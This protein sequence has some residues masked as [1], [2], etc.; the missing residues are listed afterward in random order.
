MSSLLQYPRGS[1]WR[2]W[3][4]HIHTPSSVLN[5]QFEGTDEEDKWSKYLMKLNGLQNISVLG[6]TDYFS[7]DGY[8]RVREWKAQGKLDNIALI[9]PNVE[10]RI[11]PVTAED[12]AINLHL[13]ISPSITDDLESKL[14]SSLEFK[15]RGDNFKCTKSDLIN[16]GRKFK[17]STALEEKAAYKVGLEQ[18]KVSYT[19]VEEILRKD[20]TL[21]DNVLVVVSNSSKDGLS[22]IQHSGLVATREQIYRFA[23]C[24][25]SGNPNDRLYFIGEGS[26]NPEEVIRKYG[27]LKPCIH[28]SDAHCLDDICKPELERFTWIKADPSFEG[29]KQVVYEPSARVRIQEYKPEEKADYLVIDQVRFV[30]NSGRRLFSSK[31]IETNP[32][33]N[34]IIGGKSSGKSLLLFHIAK[35]ID[36][37]QVLE[38][39]KDT[40]IDYKF[41][42][43]DFE[44]QWKD[45]VIQKL[46]DP[47]SKR[48]RNITY[49]P[50]LYINTLAERRQEESLNNL[51]F[52][53]LGQNIAF[54]E[55]LAKEQAKI[56]GNTDTIAREVISLFTLLTEQ[57]GH[58]LDLKE[59]GDKTAITKELA[60]IKKQMDDLR[61]KSGMSADE[62][63]QYKLLTE[64]KED[65]ERE[66]KRLR[67][68]IDD[69]ENL[70]KYIKEQSNKFIQDVQ[71]RID[72]RKLVFAGDPEV[73]SIYDSIKRNIDNQVA[74]VVSQL[75]SK[76]FAILEELVLKQ[77]NIIE[78]KSKNEESLKPYLTKFKN[79]VLLQTLQSKSAEQS[80]LLVKI[81]TKEK[82]IKITEDKIVRVKDNIFK[83]YD[84][85][86]K[87]YQSIGSELGRDEYKKIEDIELQANLIFNSVKFSTQFED[88]LDKRL[89]LHTSLPFFNNDKQ[90]VYS[91]ADHLTNVKVMFNSILKGGDDNVKL[92]TNRTSKDAIAKL[93]EDYFL[94]R[95]NL[96]QHGDAIME[97]SPGK[98]GLV[99]LKLYLHLSNATDPILIDQPEDNLDN[100]TI[101]SELSEFIKTKKVKR[102]LIMISHNPNLVVSTDSEEIIVANQ[103]GQEPGRENKEYKFEFVSGALENQFEDTC[104]KGV[105]LKKG[106]RDHVCEILEGGK[107][108]FEKR[109]R[110]YGFTKWT[111]H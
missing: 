19:Q 109:E 111:S 94:I 6:I 104:Q 89:D 102:Q 56:K 58:K 67:M 80:Q 39:I 45:G 51:I 11:L 24:I 30:D 34:S 100:R 85:T 14:F 20:K 86:F 60:K 47:T 105:L 70:K 84:N 77:N 108:A 98:R 57:E 93:M 54:Q 63:E 59:L 41:D 26:D 44:V 48:N 82:E 46:S 87:I 83:F 36:P 74:K 101:Y 13:I 12:I 78:D 95:F 18:F 5:D 43:F 40:T 64:Q 16:L 69:L 110:K 79:Q 62:N 3:D 9:L 32:N 96:I 91:E 76:E 2:I 53:I 99:L 68:V 23:H 61:L 17:N 106:I 35:T 7:I 1:E 31:W 65:T 49:L 15:Y 38:R 107:D 90:Y 4:L 88:M 71:S 21:S 27:S 8:L 28:G 33:L 73:I 37:K 22:G 66:E 97:M 25:F 29:L 42:D 92:K 75:I 50:Q 103:D 52:E 10:L 55:F 72:E 81:E